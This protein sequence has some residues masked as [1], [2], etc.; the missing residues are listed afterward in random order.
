MAKISLKL[1][2]E[3]AEGRLTIGVESAHMK[4][5]AARYL[6]LGFKQQDSALDARTGRILLSFRQGAG[7]QV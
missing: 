2:G 1:S 6:A 4:D 3:S 7:A 5:A